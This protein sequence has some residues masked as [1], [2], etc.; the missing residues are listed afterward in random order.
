V[1]DQRAASLTRQVSD[2]HSLHHLAAELYPICRSITGNGVR[3]TL[4]RVAE[5]VP[6]TIHEVPSG[7]RVLD[8]TVPNEWNIRD[9][10]VAT[11]GGR[12]VIDF[13]ICN[14]HVVNYSRPFRARVSRE[15]LQ[16]HLHSLPAHPDWIPYKTTYYDDDWG[17]CISE[18]QRETLRDAEYDVCIDSTYG[19]GSLTYGELVVPGQ[20]PEEV[21]LSAHICHPSLANDNLSGLVTLVA[22]AQAL[23][24]GQ[25]RYTH[26][27]IFAPGTIGALTWLAQHDDAIAR[28]RH[29][30][31]V[32][33]IG[34]RAGFTYKRSRR[35]AAEIDLTLEHVLTHLEGEHSVRPFSPDGYDERQ[36]C[37]PGF[38]LPVGRLTRTPNGEYPEYHT[39]A[40][41]MALISPERLEES[42]GV[43]QEVLAVL[44]GNERL[45]NRC[46]KGE[47]QLGRRGIYEALRGTAGAAEVSAAVGWVLNFSDGSSTLLD[48]AARSKI[49]FLWIRRA[50]DLLRRFE[51]LSPEPPER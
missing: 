41:N 25:M 51:L 22:V 18:R 38:D 49:S 29:G 40:D 34:N 26:R 8:W 33:C 39:S 36:Y 5:Y 15:E 9:A 42:V 32:T 16:K 50:A 3:E 46:P 1:T 7:T 35:G 21:L 23:R 45:W 11:V 4:S 12:R 19:P 43:L 10:Y 17:F 20:G 47:P 14:L 48:I 2:G 31:V 37:S 24:P 30:L 6:L 28:L 13:R 27:F 44:D